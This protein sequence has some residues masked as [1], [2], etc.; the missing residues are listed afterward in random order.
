VVEAKPL[1][2]IALSICQVIVK[3]VQAPHILGLVL[4]PSDCVIVVERVVAVLGAFHGVASGLI[5]MQLIHLLEIASVAHEAL[6][7]CSISLTMLSAV[8]ARKPSMTS[9]ATV[10]CQVLVDLLG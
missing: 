7:A 10:G 4:E 5:L 9:I 2:L 3:P 8:M 6:V 1:V